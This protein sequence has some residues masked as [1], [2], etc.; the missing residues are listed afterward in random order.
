[1]TWY[2]E[3]NIPDRYI[4]KFEYYKIIEKDIPDVVLLNIH[5]LASAIILLEKNRDSAGLKVAVDQIIQLIKDE[6]LIDVKMFTKWF[7]P[8][9]AW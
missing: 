1:M 6:N 8:H 9:Y 3:T 7:N 5:N 2:I 4:P